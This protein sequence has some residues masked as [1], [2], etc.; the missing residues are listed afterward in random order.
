MNFVL[1]IFF[2]RI[3]DLG[4]DLKKLE[5]SRQNKVRWQKLIDKI[6]GKRNT[7]GTEKWQQVIELARAQKKLQKQNNNNIN[8]TSPKKRN[9]VEFENENE[10]AV[11]VKTDDSQITSKSIRFNRLQKSKRFRFVSQIWALSC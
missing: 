1:L 8:K 6:N 4:D 2:N 10:K 5:K 9:R 7:G 11:V 3:D